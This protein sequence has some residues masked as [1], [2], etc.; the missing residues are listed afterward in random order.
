MKRLDS[1]IAYGKKKFKK[2]AKWLYLLPTFYDRI[3]DTERKSRETPEREPEMGMEDNYS[4]GWK[5]WGQF[6]GSAPSIEE[7]EEPT[8]LT[9]WT[10]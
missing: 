3:L 9:M 1:L 4:G 10:F 5:A 7:E 2:K 8:T 6:A